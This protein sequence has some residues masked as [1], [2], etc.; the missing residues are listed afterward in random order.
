MAFLWRYYLSP[1]QVG[2]WNSIKRF[3]SYL[4][5]FFHLAVL[6]RQSRVSSI[7]FSFG[8]PRPCLDDFSDNSGELGYHYFYQDLH[9]AQLIAKNAPERHIDIGSRIDGFVANV[10]TFRAIEI[11]DIRPCPY[12]ISNVTFTQ[13]DLMSPIP[14]SFKSVTD[15]ISCLHSIEHFGLGRYSDP[16]DFEGHVKGL[17]G[18]F[19]ILKPGGR[20]YF[21]TPIGPQRIEFNAHRIFAISTLLDLFK[22]QYELV[23]FSYVDDKNIFHPAHVLSDTDIAENLNCSYGCGIFELLKL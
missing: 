23:S 9:V 14:D 3:R 1:F 5:Y 22:D 21:S 4:K 15:S 10:A 19:Q 8:N 16:V 18:I 20:F 7:S 17:D 2:L 6:S 13:L 11:F 12:Q